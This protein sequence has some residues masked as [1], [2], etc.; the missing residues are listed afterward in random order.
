MAPP[1][2]HLVVPETTDQHAQRC[3]AAAC[4][5]GDVASEHAA[6][7]LRIVTSLTARRQT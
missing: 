6:G 3:F 4:S 1:R 5:A 2:L 7:T